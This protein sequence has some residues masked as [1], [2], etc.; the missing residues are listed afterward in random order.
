MSDG[1]LTDT[2]VLTIAI[3][4]AND[5]AVL[6]SATKKLI[7]GIKASDISTSPL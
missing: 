6:S 7:E 3:N 4:G 2:A 1:S 5:A